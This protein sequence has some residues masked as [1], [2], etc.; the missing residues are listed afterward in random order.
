MIESHRT[1]LVRPTPLTRVAI[2]ASIATVV[3]SAAFLFE[4]Y[5]ALPSLLPVHFMQNGYPNG[6]QFKTYARV[7]LPVF[8]QLALG[9][10][11][12]AVG[13]LL[14][15]RAHGIHDE[16]AADVK[17]AAAAAEGVALITLIW[18]VFQAYAGVALAR[19]WQRERAG[20]GSLYTVLQVAG[21]ALTIAVAIRTHVQLGR[22][23][24]RPFVA[25]HWRFGLLYR[26]PA[27]PALFV[28]TRD[29]SRWTLNFG[30]PIT[31]VLMAVVLGMGVI[32]PT[33]ILGL[34]LR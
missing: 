15:S 3:F 7:L 5:P 17:A 20:L 9:L 16:G 10:T 29:G 27:D 4:R 24:P 14:L 22:P 18:I 21:F 19:M 8:I 12:G 33:V 31:A 34:L 6:W 25:E 32:G 13:A 28:P 26:N 1:R 2:V 30:R 23:A 11:L